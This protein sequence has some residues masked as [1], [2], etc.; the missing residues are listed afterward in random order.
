MYETPTFETADG[1]CIGYRVLGVQHVGPALVMINGMSSIMDDWMDLA[2]AFAKTRK[3]V[4]F[5]HRGMGESRMPSDADEDLTIEKMA[6]DVVELATH[7]HLH[8]VHLLG[9]SMGGMVAQALLTLPNAYSTVDG[10]GVGIDGLEVRR[11][12]LASTFVRAPRTEFNPR[13]LRVHSKLPRP[14]RQRKRVEYLFKLQYDPDVLG[15]GNVLQSKFQERVQ[16]SLQSHRPPLIIG[17]QAMA[18]AMYD[19]R[20]RLMRVPHG[21]PVLVLHG[22]NDRMVDYA[23]SREIFEYLPQARR[24]L[25]HVDDPEAYG[26]FWFDYYDLN[27]A[28]VNP[29]CQFLDTAGAKM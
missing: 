18:I 26:H 14:Q 20:E 4:L 1:A 19:A 5:D 9:F 29:L 23:A 7:L 25:P 11:V 8:D 13:H 27:H 16:Q 22:K 3:V 21:L 6:R 12:V 17:Y 24:F 15:E 10:A 28:W 2:E